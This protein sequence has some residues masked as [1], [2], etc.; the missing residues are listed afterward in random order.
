MSSQTIF[1]AEIA[2]SAESLTS[3]CSAPSAFKLRPVSLR[4]NALGG[5]DPR[6]RAITRLFFELKTGLR[7]AGGPIA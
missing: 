5:P 4:L 2:K 1:N 3:A 6:T 7:P